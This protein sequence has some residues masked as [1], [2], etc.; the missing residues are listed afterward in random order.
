MSIDF[1][2]LEQRLAY[3]PAGKLRV[4]IDTDAYNEVDDQFAIAWALRSPE[5]MKVEAVYAAPFC[6]LAFANFFGI[7]AGAPSEDVKKLIHW[8]DT[9]CDGMEQS[10][11]EIKNL[12]A[13]LGE[14]AAGRV[15][16]GSP[17]YLKDKQ[18]PVASEAA[19]DLA[20]RAMASDEPLYVL[21]IGAITNV[22][23]AL[24]LEPAIK[25]RIVVVWLG[26][27]PLH[28]PRTVEFN[29][30][31]D[32]KAAQVVLDSGVPL[33][34]IP[35]MTVA[36]AL[37]V[38]AEEL[39]GRLNGKSRIGTYLADTVINCFDDKT[40]PTAT[41]MMKKSYLGGLDDVPDKVAAQFPTVRTSWTRIIW[42]ISTAAYLMNPNWCL[43]TEVPAPVLT[44][45]G[46][47]QAGEGR[48]PIRV[49]NYIFRDPIFG[50]LFAKLD[51]D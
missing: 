10:Y 47:W 21:A 37:T 44:D 48:H 8:A 5:R 14:D 24:L 33:V 51:K 28:F 30:I 7:P 46:R 15:Y 29:L 35:C 3:P 42:D 50:D 22:A 34:L 4:V 6:S 49:C 26:G 27:Q 40:I 1:K 39:K 32:I 43:T 13:L 45:D 38:S 31:Q 23:S 19:R 12:F 20:A 9:P 36:S 25:D 41:I 16:R 2:A 17:E 11:Q 18:T